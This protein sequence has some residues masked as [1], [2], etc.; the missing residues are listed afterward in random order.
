[1]QEIRMFTE[2][3]TSVS[4]SNFIT[5][6]KLIKF[7]FDNFTSCVLNI[8]RI[9]INTTTPNKIKAACITASLKQIINNFIN[10]E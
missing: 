2:K 9:V 3:G 1:M 10:N 7:E 8:M 6:S 4:T 5:S